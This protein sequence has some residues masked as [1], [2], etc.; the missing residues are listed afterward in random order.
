MHLGNTCVCR[1]TETPMLKRNPSFSAIQNYGLAV[2]YL[3]VPVR[4]LLQK[5]WNKSVGVCLNNL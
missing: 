2:I 5:L 3:Q 4:T 1:T